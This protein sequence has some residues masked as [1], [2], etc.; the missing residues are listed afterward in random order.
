[1]NPNWKKGLSD[2]VFGVTKN[3]VVFGFSLGGI[4]AMLIANQ[5]KYKKII[6]ASATTYLC[7]DELIAVVPKDTVKD[8]R[9]T[10]NIHLR[11]TIRIYGELEKQYFPLYIPKGMK[12]HQLIKNTGHELSPAYLKAIVSYL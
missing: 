3:D 8:I 10:K 1:M 12:I 4:L 11:N 6:L 5:Y 2:Q 7:A 9:D